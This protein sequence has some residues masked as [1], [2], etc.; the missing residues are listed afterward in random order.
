MRQIISILLAA[1]LA[2]FALAF[3][4]QFLVAAPP[5]TP[6]LDDSYIITIDSEDAVRLNHAR[7]LVGWVDSGA[8]PIDSPGATIVVADILAGGDGINR[9]VLADGQPLWSW[10]VTG[11]VEFADA[12]IEIFDGTPTIVEEDVQWWLANTNGVI[13]FWNYTVVAELGA[14]PEPSALAS[15]LIL[16]P[17]L[18]IRRRQLT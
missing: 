10:R 3:P 1:C 11:P 6:V 8:N 15:L 16:A 2:E 12:T 4:I 5:Q 7:A 17:I 13:G 9:D 18:S 14:V